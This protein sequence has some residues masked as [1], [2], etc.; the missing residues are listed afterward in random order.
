MITARRATDQKEVT[1]NSAHFKKLPGSAIPDIEPAPADKQVP[2]DFEGP[3]VCQSA[4][5]S[6]PQEESGQA[7]PSETNGN[8]DNA[9]PAEAEQP[10]PSPPVFSCSGRPIKKPSWMKDYVMT[11]KKGT[12]SFHCFQGSTV[13]LVLFFPP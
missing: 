6:T 8:Q 9:I 4:P 11:L 2:L 1:R 12:A 13:N 7:H 5:T 10:A 3:E